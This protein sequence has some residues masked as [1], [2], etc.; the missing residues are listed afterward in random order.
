MHLSDQYNKET[1]T[2][3]I[4][5]EENENVI[6]EVSHPPINTVTQTGVEFLTGLDFSESYLIHGDMDSYGAKEQNYM[7]NRNVLET[8][9]KHTVIFGSFHQADNNFSIE[10]R[11][12]QCTANA[13][14]SLIYANIAQ[15]SSKQNFDDVLIDGD[16]LY[17][18][19]ITGLKEKGEFKS[20][21][22][23]FD[24]IPAVVKILNKSVHIEKCEVLSGVCIQQATAELPSLHRSL[25]SGF[26]K[27]PYLLVMIGSVCFA[28]F[29]SEKSL[30]LI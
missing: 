30:L 19:I 22:L 15:L 13:L 2:G 9:K 27:S 20:A 16:C 12:K 29:K 8:F 14:C 1:K 11:G 6:P 21:L 5:E 18:T 23:N 26:Q 28:V 3:S 10:S 17:K 4:T 24:V 25:Q 7:H